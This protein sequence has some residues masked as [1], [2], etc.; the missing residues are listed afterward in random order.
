MSSVAEPIIY[1]E[2]DPQVVKTPDGKL[3]I[4]GIHVWKSQ[5]TEDEMKLYYPEPEPTT[6][7]EAIEELEEK[8]PKKEK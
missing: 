2:K 8:K 1:K 7:D 5:L 4:E 6:V 3:W